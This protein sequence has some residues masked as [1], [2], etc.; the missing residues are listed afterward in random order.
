M[1]LLYD[2]ENSVY[3]IKNKK[4][5]IRKSYYLVI[6]LLVI[7]GVLLVKSWDFWQEPRLWAEE[8]TVYLK[9]SLEESWHSALSSQL[10]YYAIIPSVT[11][12]FSTFFPLQYLPYITQGVSLLF[13]ILLFGLIAGINKKEYSVGVK[14][15]YLFSVLFILLSQPE[16]F[17]NTI[18]LQFITPLI[19][20]VSL[21]YNEQKLTKLQIIGFRILQ[22]ICI[23]NG[24]LSLLLMPYLLYKAVLKDKKYGLAILYIFLGLLHVYFVLNYSGQSDLMW[25]VNG[26]LE[27]LIQDFERSILRVLA[28]RKIYVI[29]AGLVLLIIGILYAEG[30]KEGR[31]AARGASV[32]HFDRKLVFDY[33]IYRFYKIAKAYYS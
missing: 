30:R 15:V 31:P 26:N 32:S 7:I 24:V 11:I 23:L 19:L 10:G 29:L 14:I 33:F 13:W 8:G 18:N 4:M 22:V 20:L 27:Y 25:R 5:K 12:Y 1:Y 21:L 28:N 2:D 3:I 9:A 17:L 6:S 16:V